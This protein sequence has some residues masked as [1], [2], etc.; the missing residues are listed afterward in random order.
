MALGALLLLLAAIALI[1]H[2]RLSFGCQQLAKGLAASLCPYLCLLL[3]QLYIDNLNPSW[4]HRRRLIC[5]DS[6]ASN[7][8]CDSH[9]PF[10]SERMD[11]S[12]F[13]KSGCYRYW[14]FSDLRSNNHLYNLLSLVIWPLV[15]VA[16]A[17]SE[18]TC[19]PMG[20]RAWLLSSSLLVWR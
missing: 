15:F 17:W 6:T 8:D 11:E 2:I 12:D 3:W 4:Q 9:H 18:A 5:I 10:L 19:R 14:V 13:C 20:R 7:A 16:L 1:F